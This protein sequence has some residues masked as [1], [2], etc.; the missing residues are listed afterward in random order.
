MELATCAHQEKE[1]EAD[2]AFRTGQGAGPTGY[3]KGRG[4]ALGLFLG[5]LG[6]YL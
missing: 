4:R 3:W 1:P 2:L 5:G 6:P